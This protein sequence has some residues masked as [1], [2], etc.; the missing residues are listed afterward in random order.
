MFTQNFIDRRWS[1]RSMKFKIF[2]PYIFILLLSQTTFVVT[3]LALAQDIQLTNEIISSSLAD[4]DETLRNVDKSQRLF[5]EKYLE[6]HE[7]DRSR[8]DYL[9]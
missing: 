8:M 1:R 2:M 6:A 7:C 9:R 4:R 5:I 3:N